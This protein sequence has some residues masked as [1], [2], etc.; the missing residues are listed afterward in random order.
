MKITIKNIH[1]V[2]FLKYAI[3]KNKNYVIKKYE[4]KSNQH[5]QKQVKKPLETINILKYKI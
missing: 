3:D 1:W 5:K 2:L 4:F